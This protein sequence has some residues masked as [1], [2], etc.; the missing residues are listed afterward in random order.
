MLK[1]NHFLIGRHQ[2]ATIINYATYF[3]K[4]IKEYYWSLCVFGVFQA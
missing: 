3:V 4:P 1:V 2:I